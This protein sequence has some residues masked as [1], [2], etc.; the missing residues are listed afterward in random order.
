MLFLR[1]FTLKSRQVLISLISMAKSLG[2]HTLTEGK[3]AG[4]ISLKSTSGSIK[5]QFI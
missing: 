2:I 5:I 4:N 3:A 1:N